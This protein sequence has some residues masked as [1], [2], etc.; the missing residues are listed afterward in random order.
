MAVL[1]QPYIQS[2][3]RGWGTVRAVLG[4][5]G[6]GPQWGSR[7]AALHFRAKGGGQE[8]RRGG[9]KKHSIFS[10]SYQQNNKV[11]AKQLSSF[12]D[13]K[14]PDSGQSEA[15]VPAMAHTSFSSL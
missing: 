7:A 5:A 14:S 15:C 6:P 9:C 13:S 11:T 1:A 8:K 2:L 4:A 3:W 12:R 10:S